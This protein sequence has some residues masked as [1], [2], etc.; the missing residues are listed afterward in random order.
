[1]PSYGKLALGTQLLMGGSRG[2]SIK[3]NNDIIF[4]AN[5]NPFTGAIDSVADYAHTA[6][7]S[8]PMHPAKLSLNLLMYN[9]INLFIIPDKSHYHCNDH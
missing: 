4:I 6:S 7:N 8:D 3:D 9:D 1:M 2:K 5:S